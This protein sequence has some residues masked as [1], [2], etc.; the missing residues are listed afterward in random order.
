MQQNT[1]PKKIWLCLLSFA[2]ILLIINLVFFHQK[3]NL[4]VLFGFILSN[5]FIFAIFLKFYS[6]K[7]LFIQSGV[8]HHQEQINVINVENNKNQ[9]Y[10]LALKFKITR[11]DNLK[12]LIEDLNQ[13]LKLDIVIRVL[14]SN[15]YTLV[16]NSTGVALF[17][18]LDNQYQKL[19]L[20]HS[21]K[22]DSD[23]VVLSKEGDIFDQWVLR[24]SSQLIIENL[25][26]D[27]RFD[28]S[29]LSTQDMR[30]VLSLISSPL[31]S[32]NSLLG[33]LRLES[34]KVSFFNQDDLRFLSLV[35][36]LGAVAVENS[37]LFQ[38]TQDLAIH[39]D[40][41]ALYTRSYFT[42][43]LRDET[44]R[45]QRLDQHLSLMMIDIDFFKQYNDK[46]GHILGDL[47]L[48]KLGILLKDALGEFNPLLSRF[49]G[50]EFLVMLSGIDK[51][52]SLII[53]EEL[54]QRIQL[55][56]IM[57][58][59]QDTH[60]TVSIGVASLPLDTKDED[61]LVQKADKAMYAAKEKGRNRVCST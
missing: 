3:V 14:S 49:G 39:D 15:V 57:L 53:A 32:N 9:E 40:L 12:K 29:S 51:K 31:I 4:I 28:S 24:H 55:E 42:D 33:L 26:N 7:I 22:D 38:K 10:N 36:D 47:V 30:S 34:K 37:L 5:I 45:A 48:K 54:R 21:I 6:T 43:R 17:Y 1:T 16:S 23:L 19:K 18:L 52:K 58:R 61:E 20:V 56:K 59:R 25:K 44:R 11:Y 35:T 27:F 60:I 41:T 13:S 50:E 46:F 2:T 8:E